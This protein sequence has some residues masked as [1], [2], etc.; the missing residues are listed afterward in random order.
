[1]ELEKRAL[2]YIIRLRNKLNRILAQYLKRVQCNIVGIQKQLK[3][4][5]SDNR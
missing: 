4:I 1:M 3:A 2:I 5:S